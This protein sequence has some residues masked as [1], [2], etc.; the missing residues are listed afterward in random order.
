MSHKEMVEKICELKKQLLEF[1]EATVEERGLHCME[2]EETGEVVDMIKDLADAE[3]NC[4][5]A[6][7]YKKIVEAM[8]DAEEEEELMMKL[9]MGGK[10]GYNSNRSAITGRYMTGRPGYVPMHMMDDEDFVAQMDWDGPRMGYTRSGAGNRSQ[11]GNNMSGMGGRGGYTDGMSRYGR[12]Y[13]DWRMAKRSYT[14]THSQEDK[15]RMNEHANEHIMASITSIREM[16]K[17]AD[18]DM[19]RRIK[20]D[21]SSLIN[22]MTV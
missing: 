1:L 7:Y 2:A 3:K 13:E 9:G 15:D 18:P 19:K 5:K 22:E 14:E 17:A 11:S 21:F 4:Q 20:Q 16:F 6:E 12:P 10:M 8:D